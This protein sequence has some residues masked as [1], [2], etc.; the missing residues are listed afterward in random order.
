MIAMREA[1]TDFR[2]PQDE[3]DDA[4]CRIFDSSDRYE[5]LDRNLTNDPFEPDI[6][7]MD[8][9]E[10]VFNIVCY[11]V[12]EDE[13]NMVLYPKT[14]DMRKWVRDS[15]DEPTFLALGVGGTPQSPDRVYFTRFFNFN[16]R[17]V[18]LSKKSMYLVN[19]FRLEFMEKVV[20]DDFERI[21]GP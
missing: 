8:E 9:D 3:F 7:V 6:V 20:I 19:W 5:I 2:E 15:D 17:D 13:D 11:F 16:T 1:P 18:D 21:Y 4:V 14:F 12:D 10:W